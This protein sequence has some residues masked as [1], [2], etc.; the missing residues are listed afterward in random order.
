MVTKQRRGASKAVGAVGPVH[1]FVRI[2]IMSGG[3]GG[4]GYGWEWWQL[5]PRSTNGRLKTGGN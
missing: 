2:A 4:G 5:P 3:G 1:S